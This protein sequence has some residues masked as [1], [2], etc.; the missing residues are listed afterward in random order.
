MFPAQEIVGE[1]QRAEYI[2]GAAYDTDQRQGVLVD[3][4][5]RRS[6]A[7]PLPAPISNIPETR[8]IHV[9]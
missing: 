5:D 9:A 7:K 2:K 3:C 4:H 1:V 8:L 6:A